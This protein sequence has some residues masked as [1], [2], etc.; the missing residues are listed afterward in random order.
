MQDFRFFPVEKSK[1]NLLGELMDG[2]EAIC[3]RSDVAGECPVGPP[4]PVA[5]VNGVNHLAAE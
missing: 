1:T 4:A 3:G 2:S 5:T